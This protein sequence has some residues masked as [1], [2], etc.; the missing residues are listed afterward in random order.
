MVTLAILAGGNSERMGLNKAIIPFKGK[1]LVQRVIERLAGLADDVVVIAPRIQE[2]LSLGVRIIEDITPGCG[3][4]GGLYTAFHETKNPAV[5]VVACDMPFVSENL[6]IYEKVILFQEEMDVVVPSSNN[7]LEPLHA[8][9]R[10]SKCKKFAQE[11][12]RNNQLQL[13]SWF[14]QVRVRVLSLDEVEPFDPDGLTFLNINTPEELERI[15]KI[16]EERSM[17]GAAKTILSKARKE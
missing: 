1:M 10:R 5:A 14:P 12:L 16:A 7:G 2:Y 6:L 3:P 17:P 8:I 9:Y 4:L 13:I 11:A 15:D